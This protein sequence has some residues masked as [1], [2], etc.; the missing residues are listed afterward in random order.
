MNILIIAALIEELDPVRTYFQTCYAFE[1]R[2]NFDYKKLSIGV[3]NGLADLDHYSKE[4]SIDLM[5]NIGT[6][7]ALR[8]QLETLD[9][10][11]PTS[12]NVNENR[13]VSIKELFRGS[14]L[15]LKAIPDQWK[16]GALYTSE[17]AIISE[18]GRE[19]LCEE[20]EA[21]AVDMEAGKLAQFCKVR[22]IN[23]CSLK[24]IS[25]TADSNTMTIFKQNLNQAAKILSTELKT[26][27][28]L[29]LLKQEAFFD[30]G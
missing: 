27:I 12:F 19:K 16:R 29:I 25:D 17:I 3:R 20:T 14:A 9:I 30:N 6:A 15:L 28:D 2:V 18:Q 8:D 10:F 5:I 7:G 26:L 23:F 24:V 13:M 21:L 1:S 11:F 4:Q 22:K